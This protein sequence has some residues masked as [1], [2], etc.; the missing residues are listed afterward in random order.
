ML[1]SHPIDAEGSAN[2]ATRIIHKLNEPMEFSGTFV[3]VGV[4]LGIVIF[5]DDGHLP[6]KLIKHADEAMYQAKAAGRN[7]YCFYKKNANKETNIL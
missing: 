6:V 4:S 1:L 2:I 7:Q 5:P 3:N